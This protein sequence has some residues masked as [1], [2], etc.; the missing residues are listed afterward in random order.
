MTKKTMW[1]V[2]FDGKKSDIPVEDWKNYSDLMEG[3]GEAILI[4]WCKNKLGDKRVA[5]LEDVV[6]GY[7][8]IHNT[9]PVYH[10]EAP[11]KFSALPKVT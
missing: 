4:S 3:S 9:Q 11:S 2:P 5:E 10:N 1:R 6:Q 7:I 8:N